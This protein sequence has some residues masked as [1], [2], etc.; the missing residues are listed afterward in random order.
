MPASVAQQAWTLTRKNFTLMRRQGRQTCR[1]VLV[2]LFML[3][4][5][6]LLTSAAKMSAVP[7][8]RVGEA[9]RVYDPRTYFGDAAVVGFAPCIALGSPARLVAAAFEES[10]GVLTQCFA[11]SD[12]THCADGSESLRAARS[13]LEGDFAAGVIF[14]DESLVSSVSQKNGVE[15][16]I[17]MD[18]E[19]NPL[20]GVR[21]VTRWW[22]SGE[23]ITALRWIPFVSLQREVD[24]AVSCVLT[25]NDR[26]CPGDSQ[27]IVDLTVRAFP[28][29]AST[30]R[31]AEEAVA[32]VV[33]LYL[34]I[35][36]ISQV[37]ILLMQILAEKQAKLKQVMQMMGVRSSSYWLSWL[38]TAMVKSGTV[39]IAVVA[40]LKKGGV[41]AYTDTILLLCFFLLFSAATIAY[42]FCVSA[43]FSK[44]RI[45]SVVGSQGYLLLAGPGAAIAFTSGT[46]ATVKAWSCLAAPSALF[47]GVN[48]ISAAESAGGGVL[49][50][51]MNQAVGDDDISFATV[52]TL[53]ALDVL[54]YTFLAAWLDKVMP[55]EFGAAEKPWF[56]LR[57]SY[58][59]PPSVP[60]S[61]EVHAEGR[62]IAVAVMNITKTFATTS[63]SRGEKT[64]AL[65]GVSFDLH[66]GEVTALLGPNGVGKST[67]C[68]A[69]SGLFGVSSGDARVYGR[70]VVSQMD[71]VRDLIGVC[72]QD[73]R[74][75]P[76]LSVSETLHL[77][78]ALK[79]I[80]RAQ[81]S[82]SVVQILADVGLTQKAHDLVKTLSGGQKRRLSVSM[83]LV[84]GSR[85][86]LLDEPTSGQCNMSSCVVCRLTP[87]SPLRP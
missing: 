62:G 48:L 78:C 72:P 13:R 24:A 71:S 73:E 64:R 31:K 28:F 14:N 74:H 23:D 37:R 75:W 42:V 39:V 7:E 26:F 8:K 82:D 3:G 41:F 70:S 58:W 32:Q 6:V 22:Y 17:L 52:M 43:I 86:L 56:C 80:P 18:G 30:P 76:L 49:W 83:A 35:I 11:C 50:G 29:P 47:Y 57:R 77:I 44:S 33:P 2:P 10:T 19:V 51:N 53:L 5:I 54:L 9:L 34:L 55:G 27:F 79:G 20:A 12:G 60:S 4:A 81:A 16:T 84:G 87:R 66:E 59:C 61:T 68:G 65:D 85:L 25:G 15:Y 36:M 1:E 67:L 40:V 21:N 38:M 45:G 63:G 46:S 69:L